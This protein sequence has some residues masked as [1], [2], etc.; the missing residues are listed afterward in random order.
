M[1]GH[2]DD[3]RQVEAIRE[4]RVHRR[5]PRWA[6][7][8]L[9]GLTWMATFPRLVT[10]AFGDHG[11]FISVADRLR[12]GD[13]LYVDVWD[14]KDPLFYYVLALARTV[15]EYGDIVLE[16]AWLVLAAASTTAL[17]RHA[18]LSGER[19]VLAGWVLA[20]IVLTG[21][22]YVS[23]MTHLP[24]AAVVLSVTA[25]SLRGRWVGAG[26]LLGALAFLKL[27]AVPLAGVAV[28]AVIVWRRAGGAAVR[29]VLSTGTIMGV[30]VVAMVLRGEL[31]AYVDMQ[32]G[33]IA[34]SQ[35]R[36]L[37]SEW[38][39][40][41]AHLLAAAPEDSRTAAL[42]TVGALVLVILAA[43]LARP[44]GRGVQ[45]WV[46]AAAMLGTALAILATTA[47]WPHH[48][49][50]LYVPG[51]LGVVAL[52]AA[53]PRG[54]LQHGRAV[55]AVVLAAYLIGG[56][57]HPYWYLTA[58]RGLGTHV[59]SLQ[60]RSPEADALIAK[61]Q[62]GR[63][64]RLGTNDTN[65]HARGLQSW[66]LVCP[67]FHQYPFDSPSALAEVLTC[68][69][70]ADAVIVASAFGPETGEAAWNRFVSRARAVLSEDYTC[71]PTSFGELCTRR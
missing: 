9:V 47:L 7:W 14:N 63:Y 34:Y 16:V 38:G 32:L 50:L 42:T 68:L 59:A 60:G 31:T 30:I 43:S 2:E 37:D 36:L 54:W 11:T 5:R 46:L 44:R 62:A 71:E 51:V 24:G 65:A 49:Q 40:V 18:G 66:E 22:T 58:L 28:L 26:A 23:G 12:A 25:L 4:P 1:Q 21:T 69:P 56:A 3:G 57:A 20:P 55:A 70:T 29:L 17:G 6:I 35:G 45:I 33:N 64:A 67:R 53:V 48:V 13:R 8:T 39:P 15:T 27:L 52:L 41:A 10:G 19:A 61:G